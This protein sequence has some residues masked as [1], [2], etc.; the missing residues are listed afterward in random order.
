MKVGREGL[1]GSGG[2]G[3]R[4]GEEEEMV[5]CL[6]DLVA[7]VLLIHGQE[8]EDQFESSLFFA[9][10]AFFFYATHLLSPPLPNLKLNP[11]LLHP[12]KN[13]PKPTQDVLPQQ[14]SLLNEVGGR[15]GKIVE[16][17]KLFC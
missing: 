2:G 14:L 11:P 12:L 7:S 6:V 3:G 1:D 10:V 5:E 8:R 15:T 13:Q 9:A 17:S 4:R 16:M